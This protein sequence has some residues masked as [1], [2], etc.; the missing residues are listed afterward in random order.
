MLKLFLVDKK[1][2]SEIQMLKVENQKVI[3]AA[4]LEQ[5]EPLSDFHL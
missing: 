1:Y 4:A 3:G 2:E 5:G